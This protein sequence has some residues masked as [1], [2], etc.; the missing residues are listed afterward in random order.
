ME[1]RKTL[2]FSKTKSSKLLD[3]MGNGGPSE[4]DENR[5]I[6]KHIIVIFQNTTKGK[7]KQNTCMSR[8]RTQSA[9]ELFSDDIQ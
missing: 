8:N 1:G 4:T 7:K 2:L 3:K 9:F 5:L 6:P